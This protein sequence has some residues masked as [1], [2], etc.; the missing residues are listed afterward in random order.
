MMGYLTW[1]TFKHIDLMILSL[2]WSGYYLWQ[3][4]KPSIIAEGLPDIVSQVIVPYSN[5][6]QRKMMTYEPW[7]TVYKNATGII[8]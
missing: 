8:R 7:T 1:L 4:L 2:T 3:D 6:N 5:W